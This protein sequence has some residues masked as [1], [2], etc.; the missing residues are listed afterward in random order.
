MYICGMYQSVSPEQSN[1]ILHVGN[2]KFVYLE[3][4]IF[5]LKLFV[6]Q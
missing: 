1:N 6:V 5:L 4:I 2:R 3:L